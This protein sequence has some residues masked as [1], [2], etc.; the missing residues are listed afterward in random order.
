MLEEWREKKEK[1]LKAGQPEFALIQYADFSDYKVII[2]RADNWAKAFKPV[3]QRQDDVRESLQRLYP[4]RIATA[5]ARPITREDAL[6]LVV[7]TTRLLKAIG[8]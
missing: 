5:H 6:M 8:K 7:E 2:E 4:V 1:A 3:F